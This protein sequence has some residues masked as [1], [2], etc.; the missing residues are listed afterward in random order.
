[1]AFNMDGYVDVAE[2]IR[3]FKQ[4]YPQGSLQPANIGE[5]F[6]VVEIGDKVFVVYVAAAYRTPDDPRPGIGMA[7]EPFP[8]KTNYTRD[9]ELMNA[10]TSAWGRAIVAALASDTQKIASAEEVRNRQVD[11]PSAHQDPVLPP[12]P[13]REPA[14][15]TPLKV[16]DNSQRSREQMI[17]DANAKSEAMVKANEESKK[18]GEKPEMPN[19]TLISEK[20]VKLLCKL[21]R[22]GGVKDFSAWASTRLNR[23]LE[24]L[25][26]ITKREATAIIGDLMN[27]GVNG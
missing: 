18:T 1:M 27:N 25:T 24:E 16:V 7:M 23:P 5:P 15:I 17:A 14:S 8:G 12:I 2:R 13:K 3:I 20:Q 11:H 21:L 26:E 22:D 19:S 6:R 4:L 9:S 10:E